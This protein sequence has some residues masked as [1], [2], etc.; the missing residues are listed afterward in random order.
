MFSSLT[1]SVLSCLQSNLP[2]RRIQKQ[3]E[4][5]YLNAARRIAGL[6]M[7]SQVLT[8]GTGTTTFLD[9]VAWFC[10]SMRHNSNE[11]SHYMEGIRGCG[12]GF[13]DQAR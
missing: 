2:V 10:A 12:S 8:I 9:G 7:I 11:L 6:K 3:I 4:S 13:E 1:S 5:S